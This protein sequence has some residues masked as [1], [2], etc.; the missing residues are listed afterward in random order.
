MC[1][2]VTFLYNHLLDSHFH[3]T[4]LVSEWSHEPSCPRSCAFG[5]KEANVGWPVI[6]LHLPELWSEA[7]LRAVLDSWCRGRVNLP[8]LLQHGDFGFRVLEVRW[9]DGHASRA[10][11]RHRMQSWPGWTCGLRGESESWE[12]H[13]LG[14]GILVTWVQAT[15]IELGNKGYMM[16]C[17][18]I[19]FRFPNE[20]MK[21]LWN[22]NVSLL[23]K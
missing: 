22:I 8:P 4:V 18:K 20:K 13:S 19:I 5:G 6:K 16:D 1:L 23:G 14:A 2:F 21:R 9:G 17:N 3:V 10:S 7:A 11:S 15:C 12:R